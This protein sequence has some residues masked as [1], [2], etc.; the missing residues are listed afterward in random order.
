[1]LSS[2]F[3]FGWYTPARGQQVVPPPVDPVQLAERGVG[4]D[5]NGALAQM[6]RW[7][8]ATQA[9]RAK[10]KCLSLPLKSPWNRASLIPRRQPNRAPCHPCRSPQK[11]RC[12]GPCSGSHKSAGL[13]A[14][15]QN[16]LVNAPALEIGHHR[17]VIRG[18]LGQ[19]QVLGLFLLR[20]WYKGRRGDGRPAGDGFHGPPKRNSR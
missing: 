16:L 9:G 3:F 10:E 11:P 5:I 1:M 14:V 17:P 13:D 7:I 18:G 20:R 6:D 8:F 2:I 4:H 15:V 19:K 12:C